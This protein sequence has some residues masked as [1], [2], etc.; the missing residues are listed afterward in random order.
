M[1]GLVMEITVYYELSKVLGALSNINSAKAKEIAVALKK[2]QNSHGVVFAGANEVCY[3]I[4]RNILGSLPDFLKK[5]KVDFPVL[6]D[7]DGSVTAQWKVLVYPSTFVIG[8]DGKIKYGVN[9]AIRWDSPELIQKLKV[10][11]D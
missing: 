3:L 11:L 7:E 2:G 10:L 1:K 5:V 6:L 8:P 4:T 9:G